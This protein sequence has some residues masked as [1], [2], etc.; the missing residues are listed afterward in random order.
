MDTSDLAGSAVDGDQHQAEPPAAAAAVVGDTAEIDPIQVFKSLQY[1]QQ[2]C[3]NVPSLGPEGAE[4]PTRC[5]EH[6]QEAMLELVSLRCASQTP[7]RCNGKQMFG[8][9]GGPAS[10]CA[11]HQRDGMIDLLQRRNQVRV[12]Y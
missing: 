1:E 12:G 2:G 11:K 5:S 3:T 10:H 8:F 7:E 9:S 4:L 6:A